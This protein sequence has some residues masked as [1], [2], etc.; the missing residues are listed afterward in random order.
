MARDLTCADARHPDRGWRRLGRPR[1]RRRRCPCSRRSRCARPLSA[2]GGDLRRHERGRCGPLALARIPCERSPGAAG[3]PVPPV[4][5]PDRG[6]LDAHPLPDWGARLDRRTARPRTVP[7]FQR[8]LGRE[9]ATGVSTSPTTR[10]RGYRRRRVVRLIGR[11]HCGEADGRLYSLDKGARNAH[12]LLGFR[13]VLL[14]TP[15][16][17]PRRSGLRW[18]RGWGQQGPDPWRGRGEPA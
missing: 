15:R 13:F 7:L 5:M 3:P 17:L 12:G 10:T 11:D 1:R 16:A 4:A 2:A 14:L 18:L 8:G 9:R 6:V